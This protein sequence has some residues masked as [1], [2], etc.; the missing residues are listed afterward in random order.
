MKKCSYCGAEYPDDAAVCTVDQSPLDSPSSIQ[1]SPITT[2]NEPSG[3]LRAQ[4]N[5]FFGLALLTAFMGT[6]KAL[7]IFAI[8]AFPWGVEFALSVFCLIYG[9]SLTMKIRKIKKRPSE[10]EKE[11]N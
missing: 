1:H 10:L 3:R 5:L 8:G 6:M 7:G 9:I 4:R 11:K 2:A